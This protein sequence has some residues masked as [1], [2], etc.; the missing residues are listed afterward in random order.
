MVTGEFMSFK[1]GTSRH[2]S[3]RGFTMIETLAVIA[4]A[5]ILGAL[6]VSAYTQI[7]KSLRISGDSRSIAEQVALAKMRGAAYF[8]KARLYVDLSANTYH[9]ETCPKS[10]AT[11]TWAEEGGTNNFSQAVTAGFGSLATAPPN[12]QGTLAQ[13]PGCLDSKG[14]S[15]TNTACIVFN[16]RGIP[17]DSTG[18]PTASDAIY[19]TDGTTVFGVTVSATGLIQSWSSGAKAA[20]WVKL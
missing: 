18:A 19:V 2:Q 1:D 3:H 9:I 12:T 11:C 6:A 13:A 10:G 20:A 5:V 14:V 8:A 17:V 7:A 15:I 4:I 16:S